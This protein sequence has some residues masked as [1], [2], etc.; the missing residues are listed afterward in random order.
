MIFKLQSKLGNVC[1]SLLSP[2]CDAPALPSPFSRIGRHASLPTRE[3]LSDKLIWSAQDDSKV[4]A[5]LM[6]RTNLC[7]AWLVVWHLVNT[8]ERLGVDNV[9]TSVVL[10]LKPSDRDPVDRSRV[11][12]TCTSAVL[13]HGRVLLIPGAPD[14]VHAPVPSVVLMLQSVVKLASLWLCLHNIIHRALAELD[15]RWEPLLPVLSTFLVK[16][17]PRVLEELLLLR[18]IKLSE[19]WVVV[20]CFPKSLSCPFFL[21]LL[22]NLNPPLVLINVPI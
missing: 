10:L 14:G 9:I 22:V 21:S 20:V 1:W 13:V 11:S 12:L 6:Q 3:L 2:V 15:R 7:R 17:F 19:D 18:V 4:E 16:L 8:P 5:C